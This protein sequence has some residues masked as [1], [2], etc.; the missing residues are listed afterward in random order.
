MRSHFPQRDAAIHAPN[1]QDGN[2][3]AREEYRADATLSRWWGEWGGLKCSMEAHVAEGEYHAR[4]QAAKRTAHREP[5][6][7]RAKKRPKRQ[8]S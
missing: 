4:K 2:L 1:L 3:G 5:S 7:L 6:S 8:Q